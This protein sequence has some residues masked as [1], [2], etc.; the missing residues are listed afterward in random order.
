MSQFVQNM[1]ASISKKYDLLNDILSLGIHKKWR[2]KSVQL[3]SPDNNSKVLD[4]ACGTGDFAFEFESFS[5]NIIGIDFCEEMLE[6]ARQKANKRNS[7]VQFIQGDA[8]NLPFEDA[9]FDIVSI[10]F[11]IRNVD[12]VNK[13]IAEMFRIL[14]PQ[15]KAIILEFGQPENP[16]F[17][18]IYNIYSK[19]FMPFIGKIIAS[20][21]E[22]YTYL[23]TTAG[24]FPCRNNFLDIARKSANFK[25]MSYYSLTFGIAYI[26]LLEK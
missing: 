21:K 2:R 5:S 13:S 10:G 19:Y 11:G 15:G 3:A 22:A 14:K 26:Y 20:S 1:F 12:D 24:L 16:F 25:K 4:I 8:L 7:A 18:F 17:R 9:S 23:P 6:I